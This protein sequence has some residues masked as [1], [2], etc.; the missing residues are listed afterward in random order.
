MRRGTMRRAAPTLFCFR[1]SMSP[2]TRRRTW[3]S[4]RPSCAPAAMRSRRWRAKPASAARNSPPTP[5]PEGGHVYNAVALLE[6]GIVKTVRFKHD[7]P[8]YGVFDE[9]RVFTAG[10]V[11]G[12]I[13][14]RGVRLGVPI[15]EDIW[16]EEV[17]ETLAETGA[18]LLLVPNGS[19]FE[20]GKQDTRLTIAVAR[21]TETGLPLAYLNQVG[22]QDE[23]VFDGGSF[24]LNSDRTLAFQMP[25]FKEDIAIIRWTRQQGRWRIERGAVAPQ[26]GGEEE[27]WQAIVL[28]TRDYVRKN[29][30]PGVVL[31]LWGHRFCRGRRHCRRCAW[32]G[33]GAL[34]DDALSLHGG[35]QPG[36]CRGLCQGTG[37]PVRH[38]A[39]RGSRRR[40]RKGAS[41]AV[42]RAEGGRHR[43]EPA[44]AGSRHHPDGDL[45]QARIDGADDR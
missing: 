3:C 7:L 44:V 22:G 16:T 19:P 12:P 31:G 33:A 38:R 4:S 23:L 28:G 39:D 5:Y 45:Q 34:R 42:Q 37:L 13:D 8:N 43:G 41:A 10:P 9:K 40:A 24:G 20:A 6:G 27:V 21:V 30:F 32:S 25:A 15:C 18:E 2:A 35:N 17:C 14:F 26:P 1:S 36:G 29:G 11:P